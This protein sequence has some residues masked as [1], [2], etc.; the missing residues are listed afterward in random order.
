MDGLGT[1][2]FWLSPGV[3]RSVAPKGML[4]PLT[5]PIVGPF[6]MDVDEPVEEFADV[7]E[8]HTAGVVPPPP[9]SN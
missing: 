6:G 4:E 2:I 5:A 1:A 3:P 9:P 7:F 8:P